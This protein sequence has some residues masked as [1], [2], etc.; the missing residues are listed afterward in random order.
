MIA[1]HGSGP[2]VRAVSANNGASLTDRAFGFILGRFKSDDETH[3][4]LVSRDII[5]P[6]IAE[7]MVSLVS[8]EIFDHL[9]NRHE[10][11]PQLAIDLAAGARERVTIDLCEQAA[12]TNDMPRFVQ[13]LHLNGRLTPSMIM[14]GLCMGN[15][16]F[17]EWALAEL[18]GLPHS[19]TWVMIH[20][21]GPLGV[22][23]LFERAGLPVRMTNA[24]RAALA[25]YHET[26][27]DDGP[28]A[29]ERFRARMIERILTRF[30]AIPPQDLDYLLE[31]L[32]AYAA[33]RDGS[34]KVKT[35]QASAMKASA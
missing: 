6:H 35:D 3:K 26:D 20:D 10:L 7:K 29:E 19:R 23:N 5:P 32:D 2:A 25:V 30:Q 34:L 16:K 28:N 11:P 22:K 21:A 9:V 33:Y 13:Q 31:K 24:F 18:A 12:R 8:G 1:E 4:A 15:V 27:M 17:V 14:R